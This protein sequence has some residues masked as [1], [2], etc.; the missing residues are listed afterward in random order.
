VRALV[1]GLSLLLLAG[2][3][4]LLCQADTSGSATVTVHARVDPN[5]AVSARSSVVDAGTVQTG[6]FTATCEFRVDANKQQVSLYACASDLY[7]GD[8]PAN[9]EVA[10][11][12]LKLSSGIVITPT[13]A[14]PMAG[15]SNVAAFVGPTEL[16]GGFPCRRTETVVFESSQNNRFS[17]SVFVT[18]TWTQD[19]PEKPMGEYSGKVRLVAFVFGQADA[20]R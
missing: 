17:Q 1:L 12:A 15:G 5:V 20:S 14:S 8:D 13:H 19:D 10:P 3:V 7:K 16:I 18:V 6:D 9:R 2:G 11:I 4:A